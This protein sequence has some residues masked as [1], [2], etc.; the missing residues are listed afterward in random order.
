MHHFV[1]I[2]KASHPPF[3]LT[4]VFPTNNIYYLNKLLFFP[5]ASQPGRIL[6]GSQVRNAEEYNKCV[7]PFRGRT[8]LNASLRFALV[9]GNTGTVG[10][11]PESFDEMLASHSRPLFVPRSPVIFEVPPRVFSTIPSESE[12]PVDMSINNSSERSLSSSCGLTSSN[13]TN[14]SAG[15]CCPAAQVKKDVTSLLE[16]FQRDLDHAM[17]RLSASTT[18]NLDHSSVK[19]TMRSSSSPFICSFCN[20]SVSGQ[21]FTCHDCSTIVVSASTWFCLIAL[22]SLQCSQCKTYNTICPVSNVRHTFQLQGLSTLAQRP[23][24]N[25]RQTPNEL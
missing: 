15:S 13:R 3:Q 16:S 1:F 19:T 22:T 18:L 4:R 24:P 9:D 11:L 5:D 8:W 12:A 21:W 20:K 7:V 14:D 6:I 23:V 10:Q 2:P 25:E 17:G